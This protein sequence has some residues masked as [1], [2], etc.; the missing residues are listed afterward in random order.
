MPS[1]QIFQRIT[2]Q[3][4]RSVDI[5]DLYIMDLFF[6]PFLQRLVW[7]DCMYTSIMLFPRDVHMKYCIC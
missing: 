4:Q 5:H 1:I 3:T 2:I 6:L 7:Q